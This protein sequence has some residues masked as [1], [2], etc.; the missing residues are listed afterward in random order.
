M[1]REMTPSWGR[2][3]VIW[4][5]MVLLVV[6]LSMGWHRVAAIFPNHVSALL[7][8]MGLVLGAII[9]GARVLWFVWDRIP[10]HPQRREVLK[11]AS[12]VA[13]AAVLGAAFLERDDLR[14]RE[15]EI[16]IPGLPRDLHGLRLVQI[17]DLHLSPLVSEDLVARA[18]DLAN[19]LL[20]HVIL[21]TGDLISRR[22][23]PLDTCLK[24]VARLKA[25]SGVLGCMG[26]HEI[27]AESEE[28]TKQA[29]ARFGADFLRMEN[30]I[31]KFGSAKIN[32]AGVDYQSK[33]VGPYLVGAEKLVVP[34]TLNVL[35]SHNPDVFPV[36]AKQGFPL[37]LAGHTHGGQVRVEILK[38]N[39]NVARFYT[40]YVD[41]LYR[42]GESSIFV[43][44]G[45]GTVGLPARLG[46]PPEVALIK[47]CA[48]SS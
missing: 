14:V 2:K 25:D 27:Y 5:L 28:Y 45:V 43:T 3:L 48:I 24:H 37:T 36:A 11:L 35:L 42:E 26:N 10:F 18:V 4:A 32:F 17:S 9:L 20:G 40:P 46:A 47:L 13:P 29:A 23:D 44:R 21:V 31:L 34:G 38:Q 16:P 7:Q 41:G 39:L 12:V 6:G 1:T 30:R 15:I 22:G 33:R 19:S 8:T